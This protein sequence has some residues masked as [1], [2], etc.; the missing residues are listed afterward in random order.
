MK[1]VAP[2]RLRPEAIRAREP[3][4]PLFLLAALLQILLFPF[5]DLD[6]TLLQRL[7]LPLTVTALVIESMLTIA[8]QL[9]GTL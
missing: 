9:P 7:M 1:I 4:F 6:G 2:M 8:R 3:H 5:A